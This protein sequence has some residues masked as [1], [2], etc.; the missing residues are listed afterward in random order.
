MSS[1]DPTTCIGASDILHTSAG[2]AAVEA[3]STVYRRRDNKRPA[4]YCLGSAGYARMR[5]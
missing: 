1:A 5:V 2:K 3:A 4:A